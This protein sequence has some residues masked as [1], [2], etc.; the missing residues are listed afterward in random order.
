MMHG[1]GHEI[2]FEVFLGTPTASKVPDIDLNFSGEYQARAH[3]FI[4]EYFGKD[5]AFRAGT[6]QGYAD[7]NSYGMVKAYFEQ[8][9]PGDDIDNAEI[10]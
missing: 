7:K 2:P 3:K 10:S 9:R 1:E 4:Q 5:H 6:V 8:V